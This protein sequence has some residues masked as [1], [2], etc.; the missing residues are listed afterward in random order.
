MHISEVNCTDVGSQIDLDKLRTEN[1]NAVAH[2]M[3]FAQI[4]CWHLH[5]QAFLN[6]KCLDLGC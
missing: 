5:V 1:A 4:T 6:I 2:L 3:S